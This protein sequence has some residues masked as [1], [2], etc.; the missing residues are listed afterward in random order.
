MRGSSSESAG[1]PGGGR[2]GDAD[3]QPRLGEVLGHPLAPLD[4]GD[5]AVE[6]GVEVEVVELGGA[7]EAV[8]V[9]VHELGPGRRESGALAR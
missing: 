1:R 5:G 8:G 6:G 3:L 4:D 2:A 9:D 7:A